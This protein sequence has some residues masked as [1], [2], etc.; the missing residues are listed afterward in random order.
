M[1]KYIT[2]DTGLKIPDG[3][4]VMLVRFPG[5]KFILKNGWYTYQGNQ[6][7]GW[8]FSS[9]PAQTIVPLTDEDLLGI[10]VISGCDYPPG[11]RPCPPGPCPPGPGPVFPYT[12][13]DKINVARAF[14]TVDTIEQ[15]D[16]LNSR[17]VPNGKIVRVNDVNGEV[18]Y[19][20][21]DQSISQWIEETF[22][23]TQ[24]EFN[25][26]KV[27]VDSVEKDMQWLDINKE[28]IE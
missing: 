10:V 7:M 2:T 19:Y 1:A 17:L 3:A 23:I 28:V 16:K 9:I 4:V 6:Y 25:D 22:G 11:P 5:T 21:Y 18:K 13:Y 26:L 20:S 12:E 14:I 24:E 15:R 8:Y 27:R